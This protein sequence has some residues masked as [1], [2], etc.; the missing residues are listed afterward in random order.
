MNAQIARFKQYLMYEKGLSPKSV[1]AYLH[2]ALLLEEFLGD[3]K[4]ED[5]TFE[6]LQQ[7]LKHLH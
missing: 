7:F 4:M 2:D 1:E 6:D 3:K 5:A